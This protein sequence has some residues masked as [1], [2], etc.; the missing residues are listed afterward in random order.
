MLPDIHS[1]QTHSTNPP[2]ITHLPR[3]VPRINSGA[4]AISPP[5]AIR[6]PISTIIT[7]K[8]IRRVVENTCKIAKSILGHL[9]RPRTQV[10]PL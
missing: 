10:N 1:R 5:K 4:T 3:R 7:A 8:T 6:L 9:R 2:R